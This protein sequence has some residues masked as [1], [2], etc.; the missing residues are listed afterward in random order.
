MN[1]VR[2]R[3]IWTNENPLAVLAV[4]AF[5]DLARSPSAWH[6]PQTGKQPQSPT[7]ARSRFGSARIAHR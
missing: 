6:R 3:T 2:K 1:K 4:L 5:S 7:R